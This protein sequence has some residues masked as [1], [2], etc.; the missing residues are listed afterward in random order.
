MTV[1]D[2]R[3]SRRRLNW[4]GPLSVAASFALFHFSISLLAWVGFFALEYRNPFARRDIPSQL[5]SQFTCYLP[6]PVLFTLSAIAYWMAVTRRPAAWRL[7]TIV[8]ISAIAF[9]S[10]D[11][12]FERYQISVDIATNDYWNSGGSANSYFTWFWYNDRWPKIGWRILYEDPIFVLVFVGWPLF[13][14]V[15]AWAIHR[16]VKDFKARRARRLGR[17]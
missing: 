14:L 10:L 4:L 11:V 3:F 1:E 7:L 16:F 6:V 12:F 13:Y 15:E 9:F 5:S 8:T 17:C 2:L